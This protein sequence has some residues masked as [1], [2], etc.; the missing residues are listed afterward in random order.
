MLVSVIACN[1]YPGSLPVEFLLGGMARQT[2]K[3]FELIIIDAFYNENRHRVAELSSAIGLQVVHTPAMEAKHVGRRLHWELYNNG[4]VLARN[5][6]VLFYGVYRYLHRDGMGAIH[7]CAE[8]GYSLIF[9]QKRVGAEAD[10]SID[11]EK[12][13]NMNISHPQWGTTLDQ[14]GFFLA[15]RDV[16]VNKLNGYNEAVVND[17]W[18]D[19]DL[20]AR[21]KHL[22]LKVE[23]MRDCLIRLERNWDEHYGIVNGKQSSG[24][25]KPYCEESINPK[26]VVYLIGNLREHR[27]I[28]E[29]V[30]RITHSGYVWVRCPQCGT[31]GIEDSNRWIAHLVSSP[32][33]TRAPINVCG[34]GRNLTRLSNDIAGMDLDRKVATISASHDNPRYLEEDAQCM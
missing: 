17:H 27:R 20:G 10:L 32:S 7:G 11:Y 18:V 25:G 5:Q 33:L 19:C 4:A 22:P 29:P 2:F 3:D 24:I 23:V 26:C 14:S 16:I 34:V 6:W 21:A 31:L 30:E 8:R 9:D 1:V 13:F 15:E 28:E 12:I